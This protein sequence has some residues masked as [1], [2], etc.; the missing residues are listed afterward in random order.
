MIVPK[1]LTK[2]FSIGI[3]FFALYGGYNAFILAMRAT[4]INAAA[5]ELVVG[6]QAH[7]PAVILGSGPAAL[8]AAKTILDEGIPVIILEGNHPGGPLNGWTPVGNWTTPGISS[9]KLIIS[10][11]REQVETFK[12][13]RFIARSVQSVD[14]SGSTHLLVLDN[15]EKVHTQ[16]VIIAMGTRERRLT[17]PGASQF[18]S[19]IEYE[20]R[21]SAFQKKGR[22]LVLGGGIDATRKAIYRLMKGVTVTL[23]TH[24]KKIHSEP[25]QQKTLGE[26]VEKGK[27]QILYG[28]ELK[29]IIGENGTL[30]AARL[31]NGTTLPIDHIAVGIGRE[32][33][34]KL[35]ASQLELA[36]DGSI[37]VQGHSQAT[38]RPGVFAAGDIT[39]GG[40][41]EALIAAGDGM[42]AGKDVIRYL[43]AKS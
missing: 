28:V 21:P 41:A 5:P 23:V 13:A 2:S 27:L 22:S 35:F 32:P 43:E 30:K 39:G 7:V 26:F 31:S 34:T 40:Y 33:N 3:V 37:V 24:G 4:R 6:S 36:R 18:T 20:Q 29:E 38:S 42:K 19:A 15:G 1:I 9:G 17:V 10:G 16:S 14:F 11:L 25:E 8:M 12:Q